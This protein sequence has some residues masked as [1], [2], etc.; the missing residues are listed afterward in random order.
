MKQTNIDKRINLVAS[1][2]TLITFAAHVFSLRSQI[3]ISSLADLPDG[4]ILYKLVL[5]SG[6]FIL[7]M[8]VSTKDKF[9]GAAFSVAATLFGLVYYIASLYG[10]FVISFILFL[11]FPQIWLTHVL[12]TIF[13]SWIL[14]RNIVLLKNSR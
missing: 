4:K 10:F 8:A 11:F 9:L 12:P 1:I 13:L 7:S 3:T 5:S 14:V 2:V 6:L